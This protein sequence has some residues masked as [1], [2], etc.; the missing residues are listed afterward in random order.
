NLRMGLYR[1]LGELTDAT[2]IDGFGAEL[3]DRF[4]PMPEEVQSLLKIVFIKSLCRIA[5][6][7]KLDAGPKGIVVQFR[8][9][10][11]P[12]PAGLVQFIA[13]N[14]V[15]AKIRTDHSIYFNRD[16]PTPD[17]RLGQAAVIM[18][19]LSKLAAA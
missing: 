3:I 1:R 8:N 4:G 11:F 9:R 19:K 17:K 16:L 18:S 13:E 6:V 5:N 15:S 10:E 2:D 12:N 7:E 14:S